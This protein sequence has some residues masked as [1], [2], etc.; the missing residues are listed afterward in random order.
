MV[1]HLPVIIGGI[2]GFLEAWKRSLGV[3]IFMDRLMLRMR[4]S[5]TWCASRPLRAGRARSPPC[6][7][8]G[9]PLVEAL[10]SVGG[11]SGNYI[12]MMA[13]KQIQPR[14]DRHLPHGGDAERECVPLDGAP[15]VLDRRGNGAL[16]DARQG[17][18]FLRAEVDDAV[19]ALSSLMSR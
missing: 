3:Q 18:R 15:D 11:A 1:H 6:F 4:C 12:Y 5:A 17:R 14:S 16:T 13:T 10:D 19:E 8:A 2:Y 9:V 7:A